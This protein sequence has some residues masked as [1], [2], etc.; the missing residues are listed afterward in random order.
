[1][2]GEKEDQLNLSLVTQIIFYIW[3]IVSLNISLSINNWFYCFWNFLG[4]E[5]WGRKD[6][7]AF[8]EGEI[9]PVSSLLRTNKSS[10]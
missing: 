6:T 4:K 5:K 3:I 8:K 7:F 9:N 1:M 2:K 10:F